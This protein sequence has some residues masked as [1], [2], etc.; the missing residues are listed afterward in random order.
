MIEIEASKIARVV[1][2]FENTGND[3]AFTFYIDGFANTFG[4]TEKLK[5]KVVPEHDSLKTGV[6]LE[7]TGF[8]FETEDFESRFVDAKDIAISDKVITREITGDRC[9]RRNGGGGI[10]RFLDEFDSFF[11]ERGRS[12]RFGGEDRSDVGRF[13]G[14]LLEYEEG[15]VGFG[16]YKVFKTAD[17][18]KSVDDT[19]DTNGDT[20]RG[21]KG[22]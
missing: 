4:G 15:V 6:A 13:F 7:R 21:K 19:S 8:N 3:I 16:F 10:N 5:G 22:T 9:K 18:T 2:V 17:D 1:L 12:E 11:I 14:F 20:K